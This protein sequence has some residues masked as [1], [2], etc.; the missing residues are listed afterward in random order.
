MFENQ[1]SY[2]CLD[3]QVYGKMALN[4]PQ[5]TILIF[6]LTLLAQLHMV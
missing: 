6:F 4:S 2:Y 3:I 1:L 5:K